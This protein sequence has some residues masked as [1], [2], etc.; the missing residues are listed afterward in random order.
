MSLKTDIVFVKALRSNAGL[1]GRLP[2]GDVYNTAIAQ[3]DEDAD[4]APLP[5]VIV[6]F[7]GLNNQDTTKDSSFG[8]MADRVSIGIEIAADTRGEL[9]EIAVSVRNTVE[10]YMQA[11]VA[12]TGDADFA[13]I[14]DQLEL[15]AQAVQYDPMK[16]CYWQRLTYLCETQPD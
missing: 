11:H 5:Y 14:P 8:G 10:E 4:N 2:V 7:D 12:D 16:P 3:P 15:Q 6:T 1:I 13:L 9:A